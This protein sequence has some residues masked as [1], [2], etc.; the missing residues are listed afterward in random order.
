[1]TM[2]TQPC[3]LQLIVETSWVSNTYF[4]K[5]QIRSFAAYRA[6][7][8]CTW[9]LKENHHTLITY[10]SNFHGQRSWLRKMIA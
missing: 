2:A 9:H 8:S 4:R 5:V 10:E 3:I 6:S 7:Q 1:M